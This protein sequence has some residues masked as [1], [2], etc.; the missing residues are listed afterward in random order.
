MKY[1]VYLREKD[2]NDY[3]G[4][5]H[6]VVKCIDKGD[7]GW[8][9]IGRAICMLQNSELP[10]DDIETRERRE[11]LQKLSELQE[12]FLEMRSSMSNLS[13]A[14]NTSLLPET[15]ADKFANVVDSVM[16][17]SRVSRILQMYVS[18]KKKKNWNRE[19]K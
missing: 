12:E 17:K 5:E 10:V 14:V 4:L 2:A 6:H 3:N 8:F 18:S 7:N 16:Q 9:P 15:A 19:I 13:A 11:I 1:F